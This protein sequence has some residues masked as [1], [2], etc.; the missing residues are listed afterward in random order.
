[1]LSFE[2][3]AMQIAE[4]TLDLQDVAILFRAEPETIAQYARSG[5]LPGTK[6]GKSWIFLR[7]DVLAFLRKRIL[8]ETE[9]RRGKCTDLAAPLL[10]EAVLLI[11]EPRTRRTTLPVL[12]HAKRS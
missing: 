11:P 8:E 7:E 6:M 1:M 2:V 5:E 10:P 3:H 9:E 4:E 12:P